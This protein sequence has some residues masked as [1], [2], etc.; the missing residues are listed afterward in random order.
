MDETESETPLPRN[1]SRKN[2]RIGVY[3]GSATLPPELIDNIINLLCDDE[4][5][6]ATC[7]LVC[8]SW[9]PASR[10][11]LSSLFSEITLSPWSIAENSIL[12]SPACTIATAVQHPV[13]E[14]M[15][16]NSTSS[17]HEITSRLS[18]ATHLTLCKSDVD[19]HFSSSLSEVAFMKNLKSLNLSRIRFDTPDMFLELLRQCPRL[20]SL[21]CWDVSFS[22]YPVPQPCPNDQ[23]AVMSGLKTLKVQ[24]SYGLLEYI[25]GHWDNKIPHL[26]TLNLEMSRSESAPERIL[27][28]VG[29][30][31]QDFRLI[32]S[33]LDICEW[34]R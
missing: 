19:E 12:S 15:N 32:N 10:Y 25:V 13:L 34:P 22:E 23:D 33:P 17:L 8:K 14:T 9:V 4:E 24:G 6:L 21:Y 18:N 29:S 5:T 16:G 7:A 26:S 28:A 2:P 31:L 3:T 20:Q 27:D 30:T 11:H 1:P